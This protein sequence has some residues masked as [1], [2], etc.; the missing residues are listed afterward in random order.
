MQLFRAGKDYHAFRHVVEETLRVA[1]VRL[2]L[3]VRPLVM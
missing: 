2:L 3:A 1:P